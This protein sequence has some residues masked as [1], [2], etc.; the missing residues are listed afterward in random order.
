MTLDFIS[1]VLGIAGNFE[2][3][4]IPL[5]SIQTLISRNRSQIRD[6]K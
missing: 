2:A 4:K 1:H 6:A 3:D 5:F